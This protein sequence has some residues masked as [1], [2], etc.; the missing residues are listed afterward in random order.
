MF[1]EQGS[2]YNSSRAADS[3]L[4]S[5]TSKTRAEFAG[6]TL[7][8]PREPGVSNTRQTDILALCWRKR[9]VCLPRRDSENPL[10]VEAHVKQSF[11]PS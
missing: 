1:L 10:L 8:K 7:P 5:S 6:M 9:T 11:L 4:T 2:Y 3:N